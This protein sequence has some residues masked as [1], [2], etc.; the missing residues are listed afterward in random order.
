MSGVAPNVTLVSLKGGQ[1]AGLFFLNS[2]VNAL[3]YAGD[4]GID[5][6]TMS[7]FVDPWLYHC[8]ANKKDSPRAQ[9]EQ[10]TAIEAMS[11]AVN[12]AHQHGVTLVGAAGNEHTDL[13]RP[14]PDDIS[15]NYPYGGTY[16]RIIDNASCFQLPVELPGV[17]GVSAVG[18]TGQKTEYSNYG[19]E[20]TDLAAPGG[21]L[22]DGF[23]TPR[24]LSPENE[25]LSARPKEL[26]QEEG[27]VDLDGNVSDAGAAVGVAKRCTKAG[28]CGYYGYQEGTSMA[29]P[30][31]AGV[32]ALIVSQFGTRDPRHVG[33]LTMPPSKVEKVLFDSAT[34]H[35]CPS[36]RLRSYAHEGLP[37]D[38]DAYCAGGTSFNGFYGHG[39]VNAEAA[40]RSPRP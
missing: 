38:Y 11:R 20:R 31:V 26:L 16:T 6:L 9:I 40:V 2:V 1:D 27:L 34:P 13:G 23:G 37:R 39:I 24:F 5:V 14:K 19:T 22:A 10:R 8:R 25:I 17:I 32:A 3:T 28:A 12:Y 36:P 35:A 21:W 18:P 29:V 4:I 30:H 7:F 33:S 15:P